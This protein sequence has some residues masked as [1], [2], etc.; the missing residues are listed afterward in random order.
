MFW[1]EKVLSN[2]E[3][4]EVRQSQKNKKESRGK[5]R[6]GGLLEKDKCY[7]ERQR[8]AKREFTRVFQKKS[9]KVSGKS[10][11]GMEFKLSKW[12]DHIS[13]VNK[14]NNKRC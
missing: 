3:K 6:N 9:K 7:A 5:L 11:S 1:G 10:F 13:D 14:I 12:E 8:D 4:Q 2:D